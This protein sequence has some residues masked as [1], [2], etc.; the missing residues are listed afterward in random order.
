MELAAWELRFEK[1]LIDQQ[2]SAD[3]AHDNDHLRRV[4]KTVRLLAAAEGAAL[5]IVVPAAWLHDCVRI[6]KSS[7]LRSRASL[8]AAERA[9]LLLDGWGY[10]ENYREAIRHAIEAHSFSAGVTP[11]TVEAKVL[12]DADRLDA[13]GAVGL[14]RCLMVGGEGHKVIYDEADPFC[15][16]RKPDEQKYIIDHFYSKLLNLADKMNTATA[17]K[18]AQR[19]V[20]F[21]RCFLLQLRKELS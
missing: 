2:T 19:R 16:K 20:E 15:E 3:A 18:E 1:F 11:Q 7:P 6:S 21:M 10:E 12:Q 4:V 8:L 5:E 13:L 17:Q 9:V 14:C